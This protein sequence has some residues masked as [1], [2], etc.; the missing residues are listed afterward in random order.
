[1]VLEVNSPA[2]PVAGSWRDRLDRLTIVRPVDRWRR[3]VLEWSDAVYAT[4]KHLVPPEAQSSVTV[5]TNGVDTDRFR[6]GPPPAENSP[7][8][9]VYASSFRSWHGAE[10][11]VQAVAICVTRGVELR[12]TCLGRGPRWAA[13]RNAVRR[14]GLDDTIRFVGL[15]SFDEVPNHLAAADVGLA[16][17][18]PSAFRA[19]RLGWFWSPIKIFEYL[20]AGLAV[21]TIDIEE[22]R[23]LLPDTVGRFYTPGVPHEL[24]DELERL[25]SDRAAVHQMRDTARTLAE[26]RYTWGHQAAAVETV[27]QQAVAGATSG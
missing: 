22:L 26:S 11:L 7:L 27:L 9:C 4:S 1:M 2:R 24:A 17:F 23:A 16:P 10:D 8:R 20:A 19:L 25:A 15:V 3:R 5:V 14:A 21:V 6:P 13:A 12:V 18:S